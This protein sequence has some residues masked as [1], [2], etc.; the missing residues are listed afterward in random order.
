MNEPLHITS[1]HAAL[2]MGQRNDWRK[3]EFTAIA[4]PHTKRALTRSGLLVTCHPERLSS[5]SSRNF[6][7]SASHLGTYRWIRSEDR[8][9]SDPSFHAS[10]CIIL[11][12]EMRRESESERNG[13][14]GRKSVRRPGRLLLLTISGGLVFEEEASLAHSS[15]QLSSPLEAGRHAYGGATD[16]SGSSSPDVGGP[17]PLGMRAL[18]AVVSCSTGP[19]R[20]STASTC[21]GLGGNQSWAG[22]CTES[23]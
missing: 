20:H 15:A 3:R 5:G 13:N 9:L 2:C 11:D 19:G 21:S 10:S 8:L 14:A 23:K 17:K 7:R 1:I 16:Y 4:H 6:A 18:P 12:P 22:R